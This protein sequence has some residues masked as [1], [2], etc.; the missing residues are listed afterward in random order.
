MLEV[1]EV[2]F[3]PNPNGDKV[4]SHEIRYWHA[5]KSNAAL[6]QSLRNMG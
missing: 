3:T 6:I 5:K 4:C 1:I 2:K